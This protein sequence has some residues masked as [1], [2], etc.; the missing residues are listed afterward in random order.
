MSEAPDRL[1]MVLNRRAL[2]ESLDFNLAVIRET[3]EI[4]LESLPRQIDSLREALLGGDS[5]SIAQRAH[6]FKSSAGQLGGEKLAEIGSRIE[7]AALAGEHAECVPLMGQLDTE[8]QVLRD[9]ILSTDWQR[10]STGSP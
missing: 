4:F 7:A 3:I 2:A 6:A 5:E 9:A 10:V 8:L 1:P